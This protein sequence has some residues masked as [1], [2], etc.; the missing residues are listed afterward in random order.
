MAEQRW[1][2]ANLGEVEGLEHE[3][4]GKGYMFGETKPRELFRDFGI[5][6][7]VLEPGQSASL[8]HSEPNDEVF[9][10]LGGECLAIV[11][12]EEVPLR[13]WD[14]LYTPPG[15]AHLI[16][17]AGNGPATV[18]MV[19]GR[20]GEGMPRYPV[21]ELAARY[22]AS[23]NTETEGGQEAYRQVGWEARFDPAPLPW[24]PE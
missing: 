20:R 14:Y 17:G 3:R 19:G 22:G 16:V 18:L 2:K 24:P 6:V 10:V 12:D 7:R 9:L 4:S 5:N 15:T 23:V 8:Y 21:S 13:Q 11:E 1:R